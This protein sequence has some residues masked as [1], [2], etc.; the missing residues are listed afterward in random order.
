MNNRIA[1]KRAPLNCGLERTLDRFIERL[2]AEAKTEGWTTIRINI[3]NLAAR[4]GVPTARD[5]METLRKPTAGRTARE[6]T[7]HP[8]CPR[9][10]L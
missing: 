8:S 5:L 4:K 3:V 7:V 2:T 6:R 9:E 1:Y 10:E